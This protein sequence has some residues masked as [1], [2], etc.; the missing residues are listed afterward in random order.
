MTEER[1]LAGDRKTEQRGDRRG[2]RG[3]R[4]Y[5]GGRAAE[6]LTGTIPAPE[7]RLDG[8][9]GPDPEPPAQ[10]EAPDG[11]RRRPRKTQQDAG[12][13]RAVR[14]RREGASRWRSAVGKDGRGG[15]G[16]REKGPGGG[17]SPSSRPPAWPARRCGQSPLKGMT[18]GG[19]EHSGL[20]PRVGRRRALRPRD[21]TPSLMNGLRES[22]DR[23]RF[24]NKKKN[25]S[26]GHQRLTP[27]GPG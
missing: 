5:W 6:R 7:G 23:L 14:E 4:G 10:R 27:F 2:R 19:S 11:P 26:V 8:D 13:T 20:R 12:T 25:M 3:K 18:W 21:L 22:R 1:N 24:R 9:G 15:V 16:A 17:A